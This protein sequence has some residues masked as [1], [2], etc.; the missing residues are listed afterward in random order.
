MDEDAK[1]DAGKG[2]VGGQEIFLSFNVVS[3]EIVQVH[4]S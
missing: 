4:V 2:K 1:E 3:G